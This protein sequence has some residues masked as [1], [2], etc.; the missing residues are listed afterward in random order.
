[1]QRGRRDRRTDRESNRQG[2]QMGRTDSPTYRNQ[3]PVPACGAL[4]QRGREEGSR[5][6]GERAERACHLGHALC[7]WQGCE[8]QPCRAPQDPHP[9]IQP[10]SHL[11]EGCAGAT[12]SPAAAGAAFWAASCSVFSCSRRMVLGTQDRKRSALG[13]PSPHAPRLTPPQIR[14]QRPTVSTQ[15]RSL[16]SKLDRAKGPGSVFVHSKAKATMRASM[17]AKWAPCGGKGWRVRPGAGHRFLL[18]ALGGPDKG[19]KLEGLGP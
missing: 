13:P 3:L 1:M 10:R 17:T 8:V 5:G 19:K 4:R 18:G 7:C 14:L 6:V 16:C 12:P 11:T 9:P 2:R 15:K